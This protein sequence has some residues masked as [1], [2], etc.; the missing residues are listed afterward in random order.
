MK[1]AVIVGYGNMGSK[2]AQLISKG[3][4]AR[5]ELSAI[6]R[7]SQDRWDSIKDY[8]GADLHRFNSGDDMFDAVDNR[9]FIAKDNVTVFPHDFNNKRFLT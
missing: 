8:V 6:T 1:K 5:M 4:I 9:I 2:Y 7:V 3:E